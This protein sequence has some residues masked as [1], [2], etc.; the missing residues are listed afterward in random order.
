[1][2]NKSLLSAQEYV[3]EKC[4]GKDSLEEA[5]LEAYWALTD[6]HWEREDQ[7]FS[8]TETEIQLAIAKL[9]GWKEGDE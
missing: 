9:L 6:A 2:Q 8:E 4:W 7:K 5:L 1:M 3:R